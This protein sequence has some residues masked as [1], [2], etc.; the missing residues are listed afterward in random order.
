MMQIR[1][2]TSA[3]AILAALSA[4]ALTG[5][6]QQPAQHSQTAQVL[7]QPPPLPLTTADVP[8]AA[9][10]PVGTALPAAPAARV[11]SVASPRDRYAYADR[12]YQVARVLGDAPPDY[13]FDYEGTRPW[14]WRSSRATRLVERTPEGQRFYY[15]DP[16]QSYPYL[17]QDGGYSYGYSNGQL[18][19]VYD[20]SGRPLDPAYVSERADLAGRYLYRA[21]QLY[22]S[23][24]TSQRQAVAAARWQERRAE[25]DAER[26]RWEQQQQEYAD[27]RAYHDDHAAQEQAYWQDEQ[28][29]RA[30]EAERYNQALGGAYQ[31]GRYDQRGQ[32]VNNGN[33]GAL[34]AALAAAA[35]AYVVGRNSDRHDHDRAGPPPQAQPQPAYQQPQG[36]QPPFGQRPNDQRQG[37]QRPND[38]RPPEQHQGGGFNPRP[39]PAPAQPQ[40]QNPA[41]TAAPAPVPGQRPDQG[42]GGPRRPGG[43]GRDRGAPG[44]PPPGAPAQPAPQAGPSPQQVEAARRQQQEQQRQQ[45]DAAQAAARQAAVQQQAQQAAARQAAVA[46]QRAQAEAQRQAAQQA[47]QQAAASQ[48]AQAMEAMRAGQAQHA[49]AQPQQTVQ[50]RIAET[51]AA[52]AK[53]VAASPPPV[54]AAPPAEAKP[55]GAPNGGEHRRGPE[56][57]GQPTPQQN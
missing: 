54:K 20:S 39:Q 9:P 37:D 53:A 42:S 28:A 50:E 29:R 5:C 46:Q 45:Q 49:A 23:A 13:A 47:A 14:V 12:A 30:A 4:A 21:Q 15:Y 25:I 32:D 35:A 34:A 2:T 27:W 36:G 55:A 38:Q 33:G 41:P 56:R 6:N 40:A 57:P 16:G 22:N 8:Q 17:V 48:R 31:Q 51:R 24:L 18:V 43:F 52:A 1:N 44:A 7:D 3:L 10:A 26:T 19:V 11:A